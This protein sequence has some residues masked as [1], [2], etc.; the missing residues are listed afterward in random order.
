VGEWEGTRVGWLVWVVGMGIACSRV[1]DQPPTDRLGQDALPI[2]EQVEVPFK[3]TQPGKMHACGHDGHTSMLLGAAKLLSGLEKEGKLDGLGT[4]RLVFQP[5]EEGGAGAKRMV[6]E[7][8]LKQAPPVDRMFGMHLWPTLPSGSIG[9]RAGTILAAS[10]RFEITI[11]GK[12]GHAAMPHISIDPVVTA[13]AAVTALQTLVSREIS[14]LDSAVLSVT[15]MNTGGNAY[16]VIPEQV[17]L[18]GTIR[19]LTEVGIN[20]VGQ[21]ESARERERERG[22]GRESEPEEAIEKTTGNLPP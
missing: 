19:S 10:D 7:G 9:G 20:K 17:K 15:T 13:C 5:A 8:A 1:V 6:E 4:V 22:K 14:P 2:E 11:T 18:G 3:S 21:R 16:N 12:G